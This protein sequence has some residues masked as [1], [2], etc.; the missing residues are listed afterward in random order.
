M[1]ETSGKETKKR[2]GLEELI[3]GEKCRLIVLNVMVK[4]K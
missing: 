1:V 4:R 3:R 2:T